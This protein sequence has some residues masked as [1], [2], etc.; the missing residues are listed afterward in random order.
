MIDTF[1]SAALAWLLTY[2]IHSTVL[3]ALAWGLTRVRSW[4]PASADLLWKTALVGGMLTATA[5]LRLELRPAGTVSL[6]R[7]TD[8]PSSRLT[9]HTARATETETLSSADATET[10]STSAAPT[11]PETPPPAV[12]SVAPA[13]SMQT[14]VAAIWA[15]VALALALGYAARRFI[16]V[17]RI[18]DRQAVTDE[19]LLSELEQLSRTAKLGRRPRLTVTSRI[20]SPIA[21]GIAEICLPESA[22]QEL[23][24]EEQRVML[25]H[26]LAHLARRDPLWLAFASVVERVLWVQPL[27]RVARRRIATSAEYLCDEWAVRRTGSGVALARCLAQVA[28]WIQTSPL[29]VPVAGMAEE[30]SLLVSRVEKLLAGARH[31]SRSRGVLAVAMAAVVLATIAL[32]PGVTGRTVGAAEPYGMPDDAQISYPAGAPK[33]T[34]PDA[35]SPAAAEVKKPAPEHLTSADTAVVFALVGRLKDEDADVRVAAAESLGKL[36][37]SRAVPGL[38]AAL[39]DREAKVRAAA[40]ASLAKFTDPRALNGLA[41]LLADPETDVRK[42]A[43][44]ALTEY[45]TGV[46]TASIVRLLSDPDA[47]LRHD[48]AHAIGHFGDRSAASALVPLL[49]DPSPDVRQAAIESL[50]E[51]HDV[52]H[53]SAILSA[54][55]DA[56]ADVRH[57]AVSAI[58]ELKVPLPD[59]TLLTMLRDPNA[60]VRV[61]AAELAGER[62][63]VAAIPSLRRMMDDED[64][65]VRENAI[66]ALANIGDD[67]AVVA[68][69]AGLASRDAKVRRAAAEALGDRRP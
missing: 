39:S 3:L 50:T 56:N 38:V 4:A 57:Q 53:A 21:L 36:E 2:L 8:A 27:N 32:V 5:Q 10:P 41:A 6:A 45:E 46:P 24:L 48:A 54:L 52:S 16:L 66:S 23:D 68:L 9:S 55:G 11:P 33:P 34:L 51:L 18:G 12:A 30:R 40:A 65:D 17:G 35:A 64:Q 49:R 20:S 1:S 67:A 28:E 7:A 61:Q 47:D 44:D 26:E 15:F 25:A 58:S 69:R 43:L 29:G 31:D 14:I 13:L 42:Q 37:D 60:D 59:A 63:S 19:R 62:S 22:L